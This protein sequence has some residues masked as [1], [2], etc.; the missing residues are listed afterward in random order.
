MNPK[1]FSFL[2]I[3]KMLKIHIAGRQF[4]GDSSRF[5]LDFVNCLSRNISFP[6]KDIKVLKKRCED[7]IEMQNWGDYLGKY[8][9][10]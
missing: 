3:Q 1:F 6:L 10:V 4:S 9:E 8:Q 2:E 5:T 7:V